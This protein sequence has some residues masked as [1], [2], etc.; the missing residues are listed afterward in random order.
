VAVTVQAAVLLGV[1]SGLRGSPRLGL[2]AVAA[3]VLAAAAA[4]LGVA[5]GVTSVAVLIAA[6][7][8]MVDAPWPRPA[9]A[10]VTA[11]VLVGAGDLVRAVRADEWSAG[12]LPAAALQGVGTVGLAAVVGA[13]VMSRRET[14][15][16]RVGRD[17]A[18]AG[19]QVALTQA[20]VARERVAMARELHDIAAHHLSGIAVMTAA[21]DRQIDTDPEGAKIAVRQVRQQSTAML[22]DLRSLVALLRDDDRGLDVQPETLRGI[23]VLVDTAR[24]AG[25]DVELSVLGATAAAIPSLGIGPL[26]QLAAYRTVQESLANAARHAAGA[27]CEVVIDVRVPSEVV[28]VVR[29]DPPPPP[30]PGVAAAPVTPGSGFGIVG[31]R[32]RADLTDARLSAGPT[33][34]GGW[35]VQLTIPTEPTEDSP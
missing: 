26:A 30:P 17:A 10:L 4:G 18:I 32:E 2:V 25:R 28:I 24:L 1:V 12:T 3:V 34:D 27:R 15:R 35:V 31:M 22:R 13:I 33:P 21:L 5:T 8:V 29:N 6:Y 14:A 20:A 7:T 19:E 16:A 11:A 9:S 23:P